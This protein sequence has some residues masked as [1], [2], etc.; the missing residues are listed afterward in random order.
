VLFD[1]FEAMDRQHV[2]VISRSDFGWA[3]KALGTGVEF[4]RVANKCKLAAHFHKTTQD[5][6]FEDV[7]R[8]ALPMV[9]DADLAR[10]R[11]WANLR[12]AYRAL[13]SGSLRATETE[14]RRVFS[15]LQEEP[16]G[17][18][19]AVAEIIRAKICSREELATMLPAE[20]TQSPTLGFEDF[21]AL[22]LEKF[23][24]LDEAQE[25]DMGRPSDLVWRLRMKAKFKSAGAPEKATQSGSSMAWR[26]DTAA[27]L[28]MPER[29]PAELP[30]GPQRW[31]RVRRAV[32]L[33]GKVC[34]MSGDSSVGGDAGGMGGEMD[35]QCAD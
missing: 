2:G 9:S 19:V 15:L 33:I 21:S 4:H 22:M 6:S 10:M 17:D 25:E 35:K 30:H 16:A 24:S 11:R 29:P 7:I 18:I 12:R 32:P 23:W 5:L 13:T 8:R 14:L 3:L 28:P 1:T 27:T 26:Q 31:R 34:A 20:L